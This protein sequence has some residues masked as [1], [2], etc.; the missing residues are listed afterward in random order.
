MS[1]RISSSALRVTLALSLLLFGA[2]AGCKSGKPGSASFASVVIHNRTA[3]EIQNTAGQVFREDGYAGGPVGGNRMVF[4]REAS[5]WTTISRQ[6][7]VAAHEGARTYERVRA[8]LV[9]L[10]GGSHRLQCEAFVVTGNGDSFFEEEIRKTNIRSGPYQSLLNKV[11][12]KL[13]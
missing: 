9:D 10:G 2:L 4:Q 5:R 7:F 6:G 13:K 8:E 11:A 3:E 1:Y 12:K